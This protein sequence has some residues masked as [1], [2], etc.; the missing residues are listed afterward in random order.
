[1]TVDSSLYHAKLAAGTYT[2]GVPVPMSCIK[3]PAVV[4]D[5]YGA[6]IMKRIV[7]FST[8]VQA[9]QVGK[10]SVQNSNWIDPIKNFVSSAGG[11][12]AFTA[13]SAIGA[14]VQRCGNVEL[15]PNS[16]FNVAYVPDEIVTTTADVDVYALIDID[17]P[18]VA[19]I[20]NPKTENGTPVTI[21]Y[22]GS[23][24]TSVPG[25]ALNWAVFNVDLFKAGFKYLVANVV[26][27]ATAN[28][29]NQFGFVAI[30]GAA[31]QSGLVQIIPCIVRPLGAIRLDYDYSNVFVK[32][33]MNLEFAVVDTA[34]G[35]ASA[36]ETVHL[37]MDCIRR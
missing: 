24:T 30:S 14:N 27:G 31:G 25:T 21:E 23:V 28:G 8:S 26:I 1:M 19:A 4:R 37:E 7:T 34:S 33:P 22:D 2:A 13:F 35:S 3:G 5:G 12:G 18:S 10:V 32:G 11:N 15:Q 6:A 29:S 36:A 17:Y 9:G 20:A 16:T